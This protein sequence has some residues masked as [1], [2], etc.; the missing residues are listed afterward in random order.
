LGACPQAPAPLQKSS[1]QGLPSLAHST[2]GGDTVAQFW[3]QGL[4]RPSSQVSPGATMPSPHPH[5]TGVA[6]VRAAV[7][8]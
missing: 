8:G 7:T 4:L 1:V 3:Q 5:D 6:A 2:V